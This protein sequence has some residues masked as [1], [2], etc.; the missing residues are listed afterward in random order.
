VSRQ[1]ALG[2]LHRDGLIG[3]AAETALDSSL[4]GFRDVD[5]MLASI[6]RNTSD[7]EVFCRFG[8]D[9]GRVVLVLLK[10]N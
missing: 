6:T 4:R 2:R 9:A 1:E 7:S 5:S 8:Q 3:M 10:A